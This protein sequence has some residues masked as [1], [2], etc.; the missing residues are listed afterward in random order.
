MR[1]RLKQGDYG[2]LALAAG[3]AAFEVCSDELLSEA[4]DRYLLRRPWMTRAAIFLT[5]AHLA[6]LLPP[7]ADP[8]AR[9]FLVLRPVD[10]PVQPHAQGDD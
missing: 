9:L 8:Y 3:I 10:P 7:A 1:I 5:A 6:N 2:W 4:C